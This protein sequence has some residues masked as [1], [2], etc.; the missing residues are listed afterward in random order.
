MINKMYRWWDKKFI[1]PTLLKEC[2]KEGLSIEDAKDVILVGFG[3]YTHWQEVKEEL[4]EYIKTLEYK[5]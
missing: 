4:P 1:I 3:F 5:K 2:R